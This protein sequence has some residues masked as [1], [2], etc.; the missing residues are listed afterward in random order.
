MVLD[1]ATSALDGITENYVMEAIESL[2]NKLTL[3][4][5]AHRIS[6]IEN[7]DMIYFLEDGKIKDYGNFSQLIS[8]NAQ[9]KEMAS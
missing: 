2:S 5:V 8:K 3:I 1:E 7:C 6:T 4:T 9:F